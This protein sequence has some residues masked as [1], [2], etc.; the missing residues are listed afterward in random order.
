MNVNIKSNRRRVYDI[1]K[2][3]FVV[4]FMSIYFASILLYIRFELLIKSNLPT[5]TFH[6]PIQVRE[7]L[8]YEVDQKNVC[9]REREKLRKK[10]LAWKKEYQFSMNQLTIRIHALK[11]Q[12][13]NFV[14]QVRI[15][16]LKEQNTNFVQQVTRYFGN[17]LSLTLL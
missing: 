8:A 10:E 14:Q 7:S 15:H 13:T 11:E 12:N 1:S 3:Q 9:Q 2:N 4:C 17:L 5:I 6:R 16:A